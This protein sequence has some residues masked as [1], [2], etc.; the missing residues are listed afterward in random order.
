MRYTPHRRTAPA[1]LALVLF[2]A[3]TSALAEKPPVSDQAA[4]AQDQERHDEMV[5]KIRM[6]RMYALTEALELDEATAAKLFPYL[7]DS[8]REMAS[9]H[10]AKRQHR[11]AFRKMVKDSSYDEKDVERR[12]AQ[13]Y[14][15]DVQLAKTRRDQMVGLKG[16]L[17]VEQRTRFVL[18]SARFE[19]KIH[20]MIKEERKRRRQQREHRG[21]K[22]QGKHRR[23]HP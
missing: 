1:A 16:I 15:L 8:D 5:E 23:Q 14:D 13:L 20:A 12:I 7:R 6:M 4:E 17:S 21:P 9:I 19:E 3:P 22:D 18:V 11:K 10:Q 2:L